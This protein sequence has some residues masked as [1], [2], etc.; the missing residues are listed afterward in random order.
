MHRIISQLLFLIIIITQETY[1]FLVPSN[2]GPSGRPASRKPDVRTCSSGSHGLIS[3]V[4]PNEGLSGRRSMISLDD[5]KKPSPTNHV[6][7]RM[8][9][10][11]GAVENADQQDSTDSIELLEMELGNA[12]VKEDYVHAAKLRDQ[13]TRLKSNSS[14]GKYHLC[15]YPCMCGLCAGKSP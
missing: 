15:K 1:S 6:L 12:V 10:G 13:L 2:G 3:W 11:E 5:K 8:G 14:I 7:L 4:M 9:N